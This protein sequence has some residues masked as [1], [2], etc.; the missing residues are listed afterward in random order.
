M[1]R[2]KWL[3]ERRTGLGG[4]DA[5]PAVGMSKFKTPLELFLDKR[6]ELETAVNESMTW[7]NLLEPVI[8]Q[9][10]AN[11]TGRTVIVPQG[12]VRHPTVEFAFFTPDGI[13]DGS[14][15]LQCKTARNADGW[16]EPGSDEVP[17]EYLLQVQHEMFVAQLPAAD[18][19]VLIGGS[20]FRIYTVEA[21]QDLQQMLMD[22]EAEFWSLVL[23]NTPP[24][25]VNRDDVRRRWKVATT[26]RAVGADDELAT[27]AHK[28]AAVKALRKTA[29]ALEDELAAEI[30]GYMTDAEQI[31]YG[32]DVLATWKNVKTNPRFDLDKFKAEQ[33]DLYKQYLRDATAQRRFL[34]KVK[35]ESCLPELLNA[36]PQPKLLTETTATP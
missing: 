35:G 25:P 21:D 27:T 28:L 29:E 14:R 3:A 10:Y 12:I 36:L 4:S 1:D 20:D 7:G 24:E 5:A 16:G 23:R 6:G 8:R 30:Q 31:T 13:A 17:M 33:P 19:A 26:G 2:E 15:V 18:L 9:E 34:L 11:R 22:R 32:G